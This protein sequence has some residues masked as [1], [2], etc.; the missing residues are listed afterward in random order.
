MVRAALG[1]SVDWIFG[2]FVFAIVFFIAAGILTVIAKRQ[3]DFRVVGGSASE[4]LALLEQSGAL[5]SGWKRTSGK[6]RINIKLGF[7]RGG[8]ADRPV[9]SIDVSDVAAGA[10]VTVWMSEW[11]TAVRSIMEPVPAIAVILRRNR[12]VKLLDAITDPIQP[13]SEHAPNQ[14]APHG[15]TP[16]GYTNPALNV[17]PQPNWTPHQPHPSPPPRPA[18][19]QYPTQAAPHYTGGQ[20]YRNNPQQQGYPAPAA[21]PSAW[22]QRPPYSPNGYGESHLGR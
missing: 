12:I 3:A 4:L 10:H 19:Q 1:A 13:P 15:A 6:G 20:Q 11:K 16:G 18:H 9:L 2:F 8:R 5:D 7:L 14:Q 21:D 17:H 22:S